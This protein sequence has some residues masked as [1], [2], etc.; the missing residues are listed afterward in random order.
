[1]S[2]D[3]KSMEGPSDGPGKRQPSFLQW[4]PWEKALIWGLFLLAIY[5]LRD[6]FFVIFLTFIITYIMR[7]I[8]E[9][10]FHGDDREREMERAIRDV[11][12][13]VGGP[14]VKP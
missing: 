7:G 9:L 13:V 12:T 6:F 10:K 14:S 2:E 1:M 3:K 5:T 11:Q 8:I 4:L